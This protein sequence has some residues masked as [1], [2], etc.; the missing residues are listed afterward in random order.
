MC[1]ICMEQSKFKLN[2]VLKMR[3]SCQALN[4][5]H[6]I[7]PILHNVEHKRM[8]SPVVF[9][10]KSNVKLTLRLHIQYGAQCVTSA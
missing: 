2:P 10:M 4:K 9:K 8:H 7:K 5:K 3:H 1:A 6:K